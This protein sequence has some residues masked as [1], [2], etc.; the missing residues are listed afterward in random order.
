[1]TTK[2]SYPDHGAIEAKRNGVERSP[3]WPK[4]EKEHLAKQPACV[5]CK[6]GGAHK[7]EGLQVHHIFPFHY[8]VILGRPDLELDQRNLITLCQKEE[9]RTGEDHHLLIGHLDDFK[10][11][12]LNVKK[13]ATKTYYNMSEDQIKASKVWQAE[14]KNKLKALDKMSQKEKDDFKALMDSTFPLVH[15]TP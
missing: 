11:S 9:G 6:P 13:D 15:K 8:C 12:N 10:S 5:A 14:K 3:E 7:D 1:M 4:A 2:K